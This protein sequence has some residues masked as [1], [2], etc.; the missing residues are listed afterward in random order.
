MPN[1]EPACVACN[2]ACV[3]GLYSVPEYVHVYRYRYC[4]IHACTVPTVGTAVPVACYRYCI[5]CNC[6]PYGHIAIRPRVYE[7][8]TLDKTIPTRVTCTLCTR[9]RTHV[10]TRGMS[11]VAFYG[12]TRYR[13]YSEYGIT[14]QFISADLFG[15]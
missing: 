15:K 8:R 3:C 11:R 1:H 13:R 12:H 9:V 10:R 4:V 2:N 5:Y 6:N 7:N 14:L